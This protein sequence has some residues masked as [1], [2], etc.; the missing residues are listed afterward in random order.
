MNRY[1]NSSTDLEVETVTWSLWDIHTSIRRQR[2]LTILAGVT[3]TDY[4][5]ETE[6]RYTM[7]VGRIM[8]GIQVIPQGCLLV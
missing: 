7:E 8:P 4:P 3:D 2:K 1:N 6:H 5:G